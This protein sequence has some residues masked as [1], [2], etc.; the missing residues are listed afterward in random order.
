MPKFSVLISLS[1]LYSLATQ[2]LAATTPQI[3]SL[4]VTGRIAETT[5][6]VSIGDTTAPTTP[7][8]VAPTDGSHASDNTPEFVWTQSSDPNGNTV[9]YTLYLNGVAT[10][11]GISNIGN[12]AGAG[13]TARIDSGQIKLTPTSGL[14][15][16]A[17]NWYIVA[18][19]PSNNPST[20]THWNLIIDTQAP[21]ISIT[22][23]ASHSDLTLSSARP[24]D[25]EGLNFDINGAGAV[26]FTIHT[27]PYGVITLHVT[28]SSGSLVSQTHWP[29]DASGLT[30]PHVTLVDGVYT[31]S[32]SAYDQAGITTALPDFTLT[33]TTSQ[34]T[35]PLPAIPGMP[36]QLHLPLQT[37]SFDTLPATINQVASTLSSA[38]LPLSLLALGVIALLF[39]IWKRKPNIIFTDI[40]GMPLT[41]TII[42]H[43]IPSS[44]SPSSA[45]YTTKH[46][47]ISFNLADGDLGR[48]HI[49][50][51]SRYSTLTIKTVTATHILSISRKAKLYTISL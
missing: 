18:T 30:H 35:V 13:Y 50:R 38:L 1:L 40:K 25:F 23:I 44:R 7:I 47:P 8:L 11:L 5:S 26:P 14:S 43:S 19:D 9:Y 39:T 16:G 12:S 10:Y 32:I 3:E 21:G 49:P 31:L 41:N 37:P 6:S 46:V 22:N 36:T 27:E 29:S 45:I 15:D 34:I 28:H 20:S 2:V 51:L 17:Y 24:E 33:V 42:Y 48:L 4:A